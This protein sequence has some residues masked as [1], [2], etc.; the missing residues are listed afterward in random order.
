MSKQRIP[1]ECAECLNACL[2]QTS[3]AE[4]ISFCPFCGEALVVEFEDNGEELFS[5]FSEF[6][7]DETD[8]DDTY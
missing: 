4:S 6:D 3:R 1:V 2:I 5:G 8:S 7:G